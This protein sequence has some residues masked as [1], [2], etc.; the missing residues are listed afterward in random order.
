[1]ILR[2][3]SGSAR[4]VDFKLRHY[5]KLLSLDV[6]IGTQGRRIRRLVHGE[7]EAKKLVR[8]S[9]R[10][11]STAKRRIGVSYRFCQLIDPHQW[12]PVALE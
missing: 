11:R 2:R 3:L 9:L 12:F 8:E 6:R 1:M 5:R 7:A 10:R 4:P